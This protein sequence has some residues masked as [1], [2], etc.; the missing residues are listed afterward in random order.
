M[1][2]SILRSRCHNPGNVNAVPR[3]NGG[4]IVP[5]PGVGVAPEQLTSKAEGM[6]LIKGR[7]RASHFLKQG[8]ACRVLFWSQCILTGRWEALK[9]HVLCVKGETEIH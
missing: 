8:A 6:V 7:E 1:H 5:F 4:S 2:F 9:K 3:C